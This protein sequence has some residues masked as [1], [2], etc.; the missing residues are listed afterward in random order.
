MDDVDRRLIELLHEDAS[1]PLKALAAA[2]RLSRS[3]VRDRIARLRADGVIRRFTIERGIAGEGVTA[4]LLVRLAR[5]PDPVVVAAIVARPEVVR[6]DSLS[7]DIDLLVEVRGAD[8]AEVNRARD[9][10]ATLPG[11]ADV[12][13]AL[14]LN[15][16]KAP[17]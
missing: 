15:R 12:E 7:G 5:T 6:C 2:V 17:L 10:V 1:Q 13:T 3:S 14:V 11:V 4:M 9:H 16:D 8:V